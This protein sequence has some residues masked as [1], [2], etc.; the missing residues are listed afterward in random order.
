MLF[1]I[2]RYGNFLVK[3]AERART[4]THI[5]FFKLRNVGAGCSRSWSSTTQR[6]FSWG[7]GQKTLETTREEKARIAGAHRIV[8]II[9]HLRNELADSCA[10]GSH[11]CDEKEQDT[12]KR[13]AI[14]RLEPRGYHVI[15]QEKSS[16]AHVSLS[17]PEKTEAYNNAHMVECQHRFSSA[18]LD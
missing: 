6:D 1:S 13:R 12:L 7:T 5:C 3:Q 14:R 8:V 18:G 2:F 10:F 17:H 15:V 9:S 11:S 4:N 16:L